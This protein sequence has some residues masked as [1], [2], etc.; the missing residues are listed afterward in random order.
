MPTRIVA[1]TTAESLRPKK[2]QSVREVPLVVDLDGTLIKVDSL[3]EAFVHLAAT[4][5]FQAVRALLSLK[6]GR[7]A[8]K[9]AVAEQVLPHV[10]T[11]PFNEA[12]LAQ[13]KRARAQGRKVY[14]AT[15]ADRRFAQAIADHCGLFDGLFASEHG[16]NLK[17]QEKANR[18]IAEFGE[19]G[20]DYIGNHAVDLPVWRAARMALV[21]G[22]SPRLTQR[23]AAMLPGLVSLDTRT[24]P[25]SAYVAAL[26]PHQWL[27]NL[28]LAL[29]VAA[30]HDF[31]FSTL[32]TLA[33]ALVSFSLAASSVYLVNDIFDL[34][35]DRAHAEKRYRPLAAG[36][37]PLTHALV[38]LC[39]TL[40]SSIALAL[41]LGW[42]F[43]LVLAIYLGLAMAYSLYLKRKLMIDVVGLAG[44]YGIRVVAGAAATG[45]P[46]SDWLVGFCFFIFLSLALVK[47]MAEM[48]ALPETELA[49]IKGRGY[50]RADLQTVDALATSTGMV[51]VLVLALYIHSPEVRLLYTHPDWL[52]GLCIVLV[53]W[54]GR[55]YAL[56]TRGKMQH[57]PVIFALTDRISLLAGV[58][59]A[60]VFLLAL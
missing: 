50:S 41:M 13:I 30:A 55:V 21:A 60:A 9:A 46:L 36:T 32:L 59:I 6:N 33:I 7:A 23:L 16:V 31:S 24:T 40:T 3:Q 1:S 43:E 17:S 27:K 18:L 14:L 20:F 47:R 49:N 2:A 28:L 8:L 34:Q 4:Q 56:T 54:L 19:H 29:P 53:Y 51:S 57:D 10:S 39:V 52:W 44:L 37:L 12:V 42:Q 35:H 48:V 45:I 11:V 25:M 15:A 38:L 22:A 5:P 58:V 26:R